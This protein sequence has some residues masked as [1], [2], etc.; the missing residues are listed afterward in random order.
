MACAAQ[1]T[2]AVQNS[3]SFNSYGSSSPE[4][5]SNDY[6]T[7]FMESHSTTNMSCNLDVSDIEEIKQQV[8]RLWQTINTAFEGPDFRVSVFLQV[9]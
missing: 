7:R 2:V 4:M 5:N 3:T 1:L 6:I 8:V 9:E